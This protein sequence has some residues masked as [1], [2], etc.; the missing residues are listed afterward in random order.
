MKKYIKPEIETLHLELT[1][2]ITIG[3]S[4]NNQVGGSGM[5]T[6]DA[7]DWETEDNSAFDW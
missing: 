4:V 2:C 6:K 1:D 7:A 3:D 5:Y